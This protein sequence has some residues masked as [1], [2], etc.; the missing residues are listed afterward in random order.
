MVDGIIE[1]AGHVLVLV[2]LAWTAWKLGGFL[3]ARF[4]KG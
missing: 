2:A 3:W 4:R 1:R